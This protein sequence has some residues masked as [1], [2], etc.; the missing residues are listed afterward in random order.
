LYR[1]VA[2]E[3]H[4]SDSDSEVVKITRV[5]PKSKSGVLRFH[6]TPKEKS[7]KEH[8]DEKGNEGLTISAAMIPAL[9]SRSKGVGTGI[10]QSDQEEGTSSVPQVGVHG[11]PFFA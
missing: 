2:V 8:T 9:P 11:K 10:E 3:E 5:K 7:T 1:E 6:K 4:E